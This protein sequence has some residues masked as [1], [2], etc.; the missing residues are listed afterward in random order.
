MRSPPHAA[1]TLAAL[2]VSALP[3]AAARSLRPHVDVWQ[4]VGL[5]EGAVAPAAARRCARV[6][7][8]RPARRRLGARLL[9]QLAAPLHTAPSLLSGPLLVGTP[10]QVLSVAFDTGSGNVLLP[11]VACHSPAC[12][13][14]RSYDPARSATAK[15][16][17]PQSA[18][19][20]VAGGSL[21]GN[22]F[23]DRLCLGAEGELCTETGLVAAT[24]MS[25][26]PFGLLPFDGVLGLGT[27]G[28]SLGVGFSFLDG[29]AGAETLEA[30]RFAVW[31]STEDDHEDSEITFGKVSQARIASD[32]LWQPLSGNTGMWQTT[33]QDLSVDG[34]KLNL[35]GTKGCQAAFDTG[36]GVIAGPSALI[37]AI[38][39]ALNI[40][41]DC[42]NYRALPML[43]F[44]FSGFTL[45]IEPADFVQRTGSGCLHQF[46]ALDLPPPQGPALLLGAPFLQ[47]YY[48]VYD[49]GSLRIGLAVARHRATGPETSEALADTL[50]VRG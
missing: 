20:K 32:I 21:S 48:S 42:T 26:E 45:N 18:E 41:V 19:V 23:R 28:G 8:R 2:L 15:R 1:G 31:L 40:A 6:R 35:C 5:Q 39:G 36:T 4:D 7:L 3:V 44:V 34:V 50:M 27:S 24:A 37:Q 22:A 14:R 29:L 16:V 46:L 47:R 11:A 9:L 10:P 33:M 43:G 13:A 30:N 38:L 12:L 49:A 17:A 25:D